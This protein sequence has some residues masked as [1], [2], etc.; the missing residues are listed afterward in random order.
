MISKEDFE[1]VWKDSSRKNILNQFYWEHIELQK[2]N[3]EIEQLKEN[4]QNMQ[5]EMARC[6]QKIDKATE[7]VK[8]NMYYFPR[9]DELLN[10]LQG[11]DKE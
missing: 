4:N 9:P 6:W 11:N 2:I 7:W 10:I 5:I 1:Y 3:K 8:K